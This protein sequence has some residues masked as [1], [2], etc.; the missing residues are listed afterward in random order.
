LTVIA[1]AGFSAAANKVS[2]EPKTVRF[3]KKRLFVST[4]Q[5]ASVADFNRDGKLDIVSGAYWFAGPDFVPHSFRANEASADHIRSNSDL[6][7]DVDGDRW[8]DIVVGAWGEA[9]VLWFKNPGPG[10]LKL[11]NPWEKGC[12]SLPARRRRPSVRCWKRYGH[13]PPAG[14]RAR[15]SVF[16]A[17]RHAQEL[18]QPVWAGAR[19]T[20]AGPLRRPPVRVRQPAAESRD[21]VHPFIRSLVA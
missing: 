2:D 4:Y 21:I 17:L 14:Q 3:S 11:G 19:A 7:Y 6:P 20:A 9:G 8:T 12:A 15:V 13:D 16:V 5:A 10:G 18:R 1:V